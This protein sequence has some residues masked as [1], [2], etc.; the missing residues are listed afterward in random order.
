MS[1]RTISNRTI[2][3]RSVLPGAQKKTE[4]SV[5]GKS[6]IRTPQLESD[7]ARGNDK[8]NAKIPAFGLKPIEAQGESSGS[9]GSGEP[10]TES[11]VKT[12]SYESFEPGRVLAIVGGEPIFQGD[13][14]FEAN[15]L[16]ESKLASA[17]EYIKTKQRKMLIE[18]ILLPKA[19]EARILYIDTIN[20]LPEGADVANILEQAGKEFD[21]KALPELMEKSQVNSPA[22]YDAHL[23]L[24]GH[25]LRKMRDGWSK[26]QLTRYFLGQKL[27]VD[28]D[29]SHGEMLKY[30][31]DHLDEYAIAAKVK[32]EQVMVRFDKFSTRQEARKA[33]VELGNQIVYGAKLPA[34]AKRSSH[35]IMADKGGQHDWMTS[36]TL[37]SENLEKLLFELP[38]GELS[39]IVETRQGF[40]VVRVLDR[41]DASRKPFFEAQTEIRSRLE[42]GRRKKAI[43]A[44]LER[45]RREIPVEQFVEPV[46][47]VDPRKTATPSGN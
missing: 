22:L 11:G 19:I 33:I 40:H 16:I 12:V 42:D 44:H 45:L 34:V 38:I 39:D 31:R 6:I 36:G 41:R 46:R 32:W 17:P 35:G 20:G 1:N 26:D 15:S 43:V 10:K 8:P 25:S 14:L 47:K 4:A 21:N 9:A 27:N 5:G 13:L 29:I 37:A 24:M 30:Y 7:P 18:Q 2:V 3:N 28:L 23:R